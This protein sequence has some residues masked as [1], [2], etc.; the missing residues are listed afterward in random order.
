L[1]TFVS[2]RPRSL[3]LTKLLKDKD[4]TDIK[5]EDATQEKGK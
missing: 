1:S 5:Q 4:D 2:R 3:G